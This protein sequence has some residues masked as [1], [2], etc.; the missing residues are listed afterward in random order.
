MKPFTAILFFFL[1][2]TGAFSQTR[3]VVVNTNSV[4]V[5]PTNFWSADVTNARSGL[6]LGSAATNPASAFQP[7]SIVL[8]NLANSNAADLTNI[9]ISNLGTIPVTGGG[10]GA[11]NAA[12]ART[13]LGLGATWL[14][15]TN[16]ANL[17]SAIG[18]SLAALTNTNVT[19]FRSDI[20]LG[21]AATNS[22]S[23]FQPSSSVLSNLANN[24]GASLT[25]IT[26]SNLGTISV[27]NGGT[28]AT[29]AAT[30]RTNLGLAPFTAG[31]GYA[32]LRDATNGLVLQVEDGVMLYREIVFGSADA[33]SN[34]RV[35]LGL[36]WSAL[37]NSNAG[38]GLVSV[39][40]NGQV[41]SPTN[42]WQV[43]PIQTLVQTFVPTVSSNSYGT[44]ARN[45][46][47]YSMATSIS[48]VTNTIILP[49]NSATFDGDAVT[50]THKG[51]TSSVTAVRQAGSATNLTTI[52]NEDESVKFIRESGQWTFYHNISYVE[53]I[54]FTDGNIEANKAASR[55]NLGLGLHALTNTNTTNF[56]AAIFNT[57][58]NVSN[59]GSFASLVTW[60]EVNVITNGV[61]TSFRIPLFK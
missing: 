39:N 28:G 7:S 53:P 55:T 11:T 24:N 58:T 29:N 43:A 14:T 9:T 38:T 41:V 46:Y 1:F 31:D 3:N 6:G 35:N 42:F 25:N 21:S 37:T 60:M 2:L 59:G 32:E 27:V 33:P 49:T 22:A 5:Q 51:T 18:L 26:V 20:G 54:R 19:N 61:P 57:N 8:S 34:S 4:I 44:N 56:Q 30:A 10:T 47:V 36:G 12:T 15:N 23:A 48:G 16:T 52:S 17:R 40:T 50:V 45:L 13:N